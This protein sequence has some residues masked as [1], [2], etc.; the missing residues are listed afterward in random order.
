MKRLRRAGKSN[1]RGAGWGAETFQESDSDDEQPRRRAKDLHPHAIVNATPAG[2]QSSIVNASTD[3]AAPPKPAQQSFQF[4]DTPGSNDTY[5]A[6]NYD[7]SEVDMDA[8]FQ[9]FGFMDPELS[10]A[11]DEDHGLKAKRVRTASVSQ[12][13]HFFLIFLTMSPL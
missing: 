6:P 3:F 11:W 9:E 5:A 8:I 13:I 7:G 12:S 1:V 10:A 4:T 2:A